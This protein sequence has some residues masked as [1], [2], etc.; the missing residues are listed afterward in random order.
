H[1]TPEHLLRVCERV[2]PL[3]EREVP[4]SAPGVHSLLGA[5]RQSLLRTNKSESLTHTHTH[6]YTYT[7]THTHTHTHA[8]THTQTHA[9]MHHLLINI[10]KHTHT[11]THSQ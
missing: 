2:G 9:Q 7:Y 11:L 8:Q 10:G 6:T 1:I 5:G 4:A 3:L